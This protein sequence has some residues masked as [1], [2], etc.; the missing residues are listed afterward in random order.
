[1][2]DPGHA[3]APPEPPNGD[4]GR[5]TRTNR[6]RSRVRKTLGY[7][8]GVALL[9]AAVVAVSHS[10]NALQTI[11][12]LLHADPLAVVGIV[13]LTFMITCCVSMGFW[14]TTT[15]YG[16]VGVGEMAALIVASWLLNYLPAWPG[17]FGRLAYHK[18]ING[19]AVRDAVKAI[20]WANVINTANA[21]VMAVIVVGAPLLVTHDQRAI[22]GVSLLPLAAYGAL[23][24]AYRSAPPKRDPERWRLMWCG[25][26]RYVELLAWAARFAL[27]FA[28]LDRPIAW[29]CA[30]ALA[31]VPTL[32]KA[33]PLAP[34]GIGVR[35]WAVGLTIALLHDLGLPTE[36]SPTSGASDLAWDVGMVADLVLLGVE[37]LIAVPLGI[38]ATAYLARRRRRAAATRDDQ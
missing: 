16:R 32:I 1:M 25:L 31:C 9:A 27:L 3:D 30:L 33:A 22:A 18:K 36:Q 14:A 38:A 29:S 17:M 34:N 11:A 24:L 21:G 37:V 2:T 8:L 23:T 20:L 15:R 35:T 4:A 7:A 12:P 26:I 13:A 19:I 6:V 28:V 10:G 5:D